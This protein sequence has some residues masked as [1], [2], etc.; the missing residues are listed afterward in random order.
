MYSYD[1]LE[2]LDA[3][4]LEALKERESQMFNL[5]YGITSGNTQTLAEIGM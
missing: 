3:A 2:Y 1:F 5:R 4:R